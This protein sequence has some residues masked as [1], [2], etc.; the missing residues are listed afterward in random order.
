MTLPTGAILETII[1]GGIA[2]YD[3]SHVLAR[4]KTRTYPD[5]PVGDIVRLYVH[6]SGRLGREGFG[7]LSQSTRYVVRSR[8]F[9]G[10]AYHYW[11]SY[12]PDIDGD[13]QLVV[14]RG[15]H[16]HVRCWHTGDQANGHGLSVA[17]Q[18]NTTT[19]PISPAQAEALEGLVPWLRERYSD[20]LA[21]DRWL[22]GHWEAGDFDGR[23]KPACPGE[24]GKAWVQEYRAHA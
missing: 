9:P 3:V 11:V 17:L 1:A 19:R 5:R 4:H 10:C 2:L 16:D 7:G 14:Y 8:N 18:G 12:D 13:G 21:S 23:S 24:R 22:S 6:H 20:Q 15:H